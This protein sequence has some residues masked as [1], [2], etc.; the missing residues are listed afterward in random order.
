MYPKQGIFP[1]NLSLLIA[2]YEKIRINQP[3]KNW[4]KRQHI[5]ARKFCSY[6]KIFKIFIG[7]DLLIFR[8]YFYESNLMFLFVFLLPWQIIIIRH[9][10]VVVFWC[11]LLMLSLFSLFLLLLILTPQDIVVFKYFLTFI[12]CCLEKKVT[13][14]IG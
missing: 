5:S 3:L 12:S 4:F 8:F 9:V 14:H 13:K 6:F 10:V 2:M 1:F 11:L 7:Y